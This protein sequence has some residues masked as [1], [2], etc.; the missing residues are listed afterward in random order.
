MSTWC[1]VWDMIRCV[2]QGTERVKSDG[3][4][5]QYILHTCRRLPRMN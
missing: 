2:L 4:Y 3:D 1:H 5:G